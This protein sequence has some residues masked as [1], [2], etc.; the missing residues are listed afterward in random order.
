MQTH[1]WVLMGPPALHCKQDLSVIEPDF[2]VK[3][4]LC[5]GAMSYSN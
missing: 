4:K 5:N 3:P 2:N 1:G